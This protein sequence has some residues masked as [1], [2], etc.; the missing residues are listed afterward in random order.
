MKEEQKKATNNKVSKNPPRGS[1][2]ASLDMEQNC[3]FFNLIPLAGA[4]ARRIDGSAGMPKGRLPTRAREISINH[5][6]SGRCGSRLTQNARVLVADSISGDI[7]HN[8]PA[9][10][11]AGEHAATEEC[12][13]K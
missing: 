11:P 9:G 7:A 6:G 12:A 3:F 1:P 5:S 10:D 4:F 8:G 13:F 2:G